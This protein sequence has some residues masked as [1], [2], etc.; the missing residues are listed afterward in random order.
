MWWVPL[1]GSAMGCLCGG[2][3][4]DHLISK[5]STEVVTTSD[6]GAPAENL[7]PT[8]EDVNYSPIVDPHWDPD[9]E[10]VMPTSSGDAL[11]AKTNDAN[12][13]GMLLT[14]PS[15]AL[16]PCDGDLS[17]YNIV[18]CGTSGRAFIAGAGVLLSTPFVYLALTDTTTTP[19]PVCFFMLILSGFVSTPPFSTE[20]KPFLLLS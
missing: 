17:V 6:P 14:N 16:P 12:T 7:L 20:F 9:V 13:D 15:L 4:S 5:H 10:V 8:H 19:V 11:T 3:L 18:H 1:M 2:L